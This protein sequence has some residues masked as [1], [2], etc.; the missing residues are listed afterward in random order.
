MEGGLG[1]PLLPEGNV[2]AATGIGKSGPRGQQSRTRATGWTGTWRGRWLRP[3]ELGP[4]C[5]GAGCQG[6][7]SGWGPAGGVE[8]GYR[9]E[10]AV[11]SANTARV[12][13]DHQPAGRVEAS[14]R[15][16]NWGTCSEGGPWKGGGLLGA[17]GSWSLPVLEAHLCWVGWSQ[18]APR[19][20]H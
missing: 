8:E 1:G 17:P 15:A 11:P 18:A 20:S 3:A 12:R 9:E 13:L 10:Q 2:E 16:G 5:Q 19:T 4:R 14:T 6:V 7:G